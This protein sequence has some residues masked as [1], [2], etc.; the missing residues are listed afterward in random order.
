MLFRSTVR[1]NLTVSGTTTVNSLTNAL[2]AGISTSGNTWAN[3]ATVRSNL[4][5][6]G[7]S[8]LAT[9][10]TATV[11]NL[12]LNTPAWKDI[13]FEPSGLS[14]GGT[15]VTRV[16]LYPGAIPT[17]EAWEIDSYG[18]GSGQFNH[19]LATTNAVF[20][21]LYIVPHVH[22]TVTNIP[23]GT[24][25]ATFKVDYVWCRIGSNFAT[26]AV[27]GSITNTQTF[28]EANKHELMALG[29]ITNNT[30]AGS[31][32][33][34]FHYRL[35]RITSTAGDVGTEDV[36]VHDFDIH[37]PVNRLGSSGPATY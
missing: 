2:G 31:I 36:R 33:S 25:N 18:D 3:A 29:N 17:V 10:A 20:K 34:L 35:T 9:N 13:V 12:V 11:S 8:L 16:P 14:H 26:S 24:S 37:Y 7:T 30:A 5:V 21:N 15:A 22:L 27:S 19:D 23:A 6:S 28:T 4:T 32:S 1:S